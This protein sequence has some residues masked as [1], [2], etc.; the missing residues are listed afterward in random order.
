MAKEVISS[1]IGKSLVMHNA[2]FDCWMVQNNYNIDLMPHVHTDT[3]ILAHLLNENRHNGLKELGTSIF[4][5]SARE[6]QLAMKASVTANGGLLTKDKYELYK[7]DEDLIAKYGAK[8]TILTIKLFY[9]FVEQLMDEGLDK[10]FYE[11]ESMPLLRGP[12]YD[13]NTTGLRVDPEKLQTLKATLE[14]DI[15]SM[16]AFIH[17]EI[18]PHVKDKYP[19]DKKTNKFNIK[20]PQQ[21]SWLLFEKLGNTFGTLTD[22]GKELCKDLG[23]RI[24][25]SV[26]DKK[27]LIQNLKDSTGQVHKKGEWDHKKQKEGRPKKIG[28]Y[29]KYLALDKKILGDLASKYEWVATLLEY[30]KTGKL[31]DTYVLGIQE[32]MRYNIIRSSFLQH[33]TTSGRYSSKAPNFQNLPRKDKRIKSCIVSRPGKVFVGAD[34]AQLEPRVFASMSKDETLMSSFAKGLDF[35]SVV[36]APIFNKNSCSLVKDEEGSFSV[37]YPDL[38]DKAKVVALA[39]PYGRTA[40]FMASEMKVKTDEAQTMID[41]YFKAYPKVELMMLE[42]H[43]IAKKEGRVLNLFGRPRRIPEAKE[44]TSKYGHLPHGELPYE[45]RTLLNLA[46]NHRIQSTGASIMNRAAISAWKNFKSLAKDDPRWLEIKIVLQVHDELILEG[47]EALAEDMILVLK[48][49]MEST[50]VLPGV[51]LVAEPKVAKNLA[52]LK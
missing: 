51:D 40:N 1:L 30:R 22:G 43:E 36:G 15:M 27:E 14:A 16:E 23:V 3:M 12:T 39:T 31:L 34:Y 38:R 25:Y 35:Y 20:A 26:K 2:V 10:F 42:S 6:E 8:D 11:D 28:D 44:I 24:P 47:P 18:W 17:K 45:A 46:M 32:K 5:E 50:V 52:D 29:W 48:D 37:K 9:L 19:G 33:G 7:G 4:G 21:L 13:L 41:N 49:A